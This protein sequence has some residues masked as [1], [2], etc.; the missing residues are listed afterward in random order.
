[1]VFGSHHILKIASHAKTKMPSSSM[2]FLHA[3]IV[4]L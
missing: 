2:E 3:V 4:A 1:M